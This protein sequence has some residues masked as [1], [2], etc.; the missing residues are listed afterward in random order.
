MYVL[1]STDK[2]NY[3]S[4]PLNNMLV[5]WLW[6]EFIAENFNIL[7]LHKSHVKLTSIGCKSYI[8]QALILYKSHIKVKLIEYLYLG[9]KYADIEYFYIP[10]LDI[11]RP[12]FIVFL[13][14]YHYL[15]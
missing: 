10:F 15:G 11:F 7:I 9:K 1:T 2:N 14:I 12:K 5:E 6:R 3:K 4:E 8:K 13:E